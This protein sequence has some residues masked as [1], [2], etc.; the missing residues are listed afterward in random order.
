LLVNDDFLELVR[1]IFNNVAR[2]SCKSLVRRKVAAVHNETSEARPHARTVGNRIL[3]TTTHD[4]PILASPIRND[5]RMSKVLRFKMILQF[6]Q[7]SDRARRWI[8]ILVESTSVGG[9]TG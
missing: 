5:P 7:K 9:E 1:E 4:F 2:I 8:K 6:L 3:A